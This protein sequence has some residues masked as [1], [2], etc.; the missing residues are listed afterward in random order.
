MPAGRP[1]KGPEK[2]GV[3]IAVKVSPAEYD[4]LQRVAGI[5]NIRTVHDKS[6]VVGSWLRQVGLAAAGFREAEVI[7]H[8]EGWEETKDG[9]IFERVDDSAYV[10]KLQPDDKLGP[11]GW[12]I[13]VRMPGAFLLDLPLPTAME[14]MERADEKL[15]EI[16]ASERA[17]ESS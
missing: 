9:E 5:A 11:L 15:E 8:D 12:W 6:A 1:P 7:V 16:V 3:V 2:R 10:R 14:A 4:A 13:P 17:P